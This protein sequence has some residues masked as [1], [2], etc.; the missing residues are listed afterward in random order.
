[1]Y[2]Y[3]LRVDVMFERAHIIMVAIDLSLSLPAIVSI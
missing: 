1:M 2:V 3:I